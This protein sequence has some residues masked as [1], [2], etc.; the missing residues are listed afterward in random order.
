MT[1]STLYRLISTTG[2][3]FVCLA[4]A[5]AQNN[6]Q[7]QTSVR[8]STA[9]EIKVERLASPEFPWGMALLPDNRLLIT[10]KPGRL[11][12]WSDG[13]LSDPVDGTPKV[14]YRGTPNEQGG[15]LDVEIDP[16]F[17]ENKVVYLSYVE[18][19]E[20]QTE[21]IADTD[22]VRFPQLDLNDKIV[23]GGVVARA[24]LDGDNLRDL[25]VI[26]RQEPKTVG[27]GHFGNR[28]I[29][30]KD[31]TL[32]IT[33]GE[34]MRFEPAQSLQSSL[35][36]IVRIN[37]DGSIPKDNPFVGKDDA[38][39]DIW[40]YGHRNMMGPLGGDE[41]N[42]IQR[43]RNY[44]WP[45]VSNGDHYGR[46]GVSTEH[47]SIP[48][49]ATSREFEPPVRTWTPVVSPSGAAFYTGSLFPQ[50][51]GSV[52]VGGLSSKALVRLVLETDR[53]PLEERIEM[54]RRIRDVLQARDGAI[55]L[56]VDAKEGELLRLTPA[57]AD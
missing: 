33:S 51:R 37:P 2:V 34:R 9:G 12:I 43:G 32:F 13:K 27:R 56:L 25:K 4:T 48:G 53:V 30:A 28:L 42:L 38:R 18:A 3:I 21:S 35:G 50:W 20:Q 11:R 31:G 55:L 8:S 39:G 52:L 10:E 57:K 6:E 22:D 46:S 29:F 45:L 16:N 36:K 26:W 15:L 41:I 24:R 14:I 19:D 17:K 40:T 44:G 5:K 54:K 47:T 49:H 1:R 7:S 23:R